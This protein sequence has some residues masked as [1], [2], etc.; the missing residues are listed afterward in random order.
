MPQ[1]STCAF[2]EQILRNHGFRT[3]FYRYGDIVNDGSYMKGIGSIVSRG[4]A[5]FLG[6]E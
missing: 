4:V 1:G 5:V 2:T 6:S 3:G